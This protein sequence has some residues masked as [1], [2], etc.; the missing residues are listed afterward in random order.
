[1]EYGINNRLGLPSLNQALDT[2]LS[3]YQN[4]IR[5]FD[6]AN[7]YGR[8]E[9]VLGNFIAKFKYKDIKVISKLRPDAL[10]KNNSK[11]DLYQA[12]KKEIVISLK[13]LK[14]EQL[15][16]YLLHEPKYMYNQAVVAAL[17]RCKKEGLIKNWGVSI[18]EA[19]D[20]LFAAQKARADYIQ[21]PY[22]IFDQR[23]DHNAFFKLTK[24]NGIRVFARSAFLQGLFF[25]D[26]DKLP[27]HLKEA[28]SY[29]LKFEQIVTKYHIGKAE[30]ALLFVYLNNNIDHV[31]IGVDSKAQ[32]LQNINILN[33]KIEFDQ[34][35][36]ELVKSFPQIDKTIIFPSLWKKG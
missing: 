1:M 11:E 21:I 10:G 16:G 15:N 24:K 6:T 35:R 7:S 23:L 17:K 12:V 25:M 31:I 19:S 27:S 5:Y 22:N 14:S 34:C 36:Q 3:A 8:A 32:L 30:A 29:L 13:N 26:I 9:E 18:Y 20:A 28:K 33:K 2:L 4:N